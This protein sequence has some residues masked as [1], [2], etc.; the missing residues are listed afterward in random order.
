MG[1]E[2]AGIYRL[3]TASDA[4]W[5]AQVAYRKREGIWQRLS[6][7]AGAMLRLVVP[8]MLLV[9]ALAGTYLYLDT[10]LPYFADGGAAWLS[11]GHALV[12]ATFFVVALTNRRYGASYAFVQVAVSIVVIVAA[13]AFA[14]DSL[15]GLI[16]AHAVPTARFAMAFGGAFFVTSF[17]SILMFDGARGPRWWTAPLVGLISAALV[18]P[19]I[20]FPAAF[21]GTTDTVWF[22]HMFVF[23]G[24]MFAA[25]F[26]ALIP[27]WLLRSMVPPL[28]GFGGY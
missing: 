6:Q 23:G 16:P 28:S 9:S 14:S 24:L 17:V 2:D 12:P 18:F 8:V 22:N 27:Y 3:R 15:R 19:A 10:K 13:L 26:A 1:V 5:P 7:G 20:F 21:A 11:V 25:A 4:A